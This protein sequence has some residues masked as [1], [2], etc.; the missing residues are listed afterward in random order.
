MIKIRLR[1]AVWALAAATALALSGCGSAVSWYA[2]WHVN[3]SGND[4]DQFKPESDL[5]LIESAQRFGLMALLAEAAYRRDLKLDARDTQGCAY[6][7]APPGTPPPTYGLPI[8]KSGAWVRWVPS[9]GSGVDVEACRDDE[10]GLHYETYVHQTAPGQFDEAVIAFR[11]TENRAGQTIR[12]WRSNLAATFG[13]EPAQYVVARERMLPLINLLADTLK[14]QGHPENVY[15]VGHSLGGGL[16]QQAGYLSKRVKAVYTFNTSPISNWSQLR[17]RK[18]VGNA[19]P[20]IHRVYHNGEILEKLRFVTNT[21][22]STRYGRNDLGFQL[23]SKSNF[24]GHSIQM[25][26]CTFAEL[27]LLAPSAEEAD[28]HYPISFIRDKLLIREDADQPCSKA[29]AEDKV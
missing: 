11:G 3:D 1:A 26:A 19:W 23:A 29:K 5:Y 28:H 2:G 13:M 27:I 7:Q 16:A 20:V 4:T 17:L 14:A 9:A 6:L 21:A 25:M 18:E 8:G 10:S 22:T 15:A 12:D 24:G